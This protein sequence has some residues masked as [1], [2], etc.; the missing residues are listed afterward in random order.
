[1]AQTRKVD[2]EFV[3]TLEVLSKAWEST[4]NRDTLLS[5]EQ[6][7]TYAYA[8]SQFIKWTQGKPRSHLPSS[9]EVR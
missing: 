4:L 3:R 6:K 7:L 5:R 2:D 8:V 9:Q 1:M